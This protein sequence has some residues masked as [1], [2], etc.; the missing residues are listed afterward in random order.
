MYIQE[1]RLR[2]G[3]MKSVRSFRPS[4]V[5]MRSKAWYDTLQRLHRWSL[6][7]DK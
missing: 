3:G 7:M 1:I 6:E 4:E 2:N 5:Y